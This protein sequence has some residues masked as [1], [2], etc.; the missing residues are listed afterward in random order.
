M[1]PSSE[2]YEQVCKAE[3]GS[4]HAKLD[5][6][7]EAIRGNGKPGIQLRLDRLES[8]RAVRSRLVWLIVG[9]AVTLAV[10]GLWKF[11]C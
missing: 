3:F 2:Q 4:L 5:R 7:D 8:A 11:F 1:C 10:G 9:A 6:M